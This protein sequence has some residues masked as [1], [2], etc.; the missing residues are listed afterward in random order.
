MPDVK[1]LILVERDKKKAIDSIADDLCRIGLTV[2]NKM[3]ISGTISGWA[4]VEK[5]DEMRKVE[6]VAELREEKIFSLPPMDGKI[7]Q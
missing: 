3:S 4:S 7:P 5:I 1:L 2:D 6:G